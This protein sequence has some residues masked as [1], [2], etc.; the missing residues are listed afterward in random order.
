MKSSALFAVS[1]LVSLVAVSGLAGTT[2]LEKTSDGYQI[3]VDGEPYFVKGAGGDASKEVLVEV[4]GNTF[5][6]WGI[7]PETRKQ[8]DEAQRLGLKVSVGIWLGHGRHGFDYDN[9]AEVQAQFDAAEQAVRE[10]K[11]H[12]AIL[13]WCVGNEMEVGLEGATRAKRSRRAWRRGR[14]KAPRFGSGKP[15]CSSVSRSTCVRSSN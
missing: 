14:S 5:R 12:P 7:G 6:T 8:L 2:T 13:L 3:L 9:P 4:G 11:D 1:M 15:R 10:L